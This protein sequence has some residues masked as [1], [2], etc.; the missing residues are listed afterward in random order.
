MSALG[1]PHR[2]VAEAGAGPQWAVLGY[3]TGWHDTIDG[4]D[5]TVSMGFAFANK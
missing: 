3:G 4:S 2:S 5:F 1:K